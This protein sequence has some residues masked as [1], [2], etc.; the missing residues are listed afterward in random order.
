MKDA[1]FAIINEYSAMKGYPLWALKYMSDVF[2]NSLPKLTMNDEV[3][4][5]IDNIIA[6]CNGNDQKNVQLVTSTL[7]LI[8]RYRADFPDILNKENSFHNGFV[9]FLYSVEK[10]DLEHEEVEDAIDYLKK[11]LQTTTGYWTED[12]VSVALRNWRIEKNA[13]IV[14]RRRREE[15]E[16]HRREVDKFADKADK[17]TAIIGDENKARSKKVDARELIDHI[18]DPEML[19][20]IIDRII[21]LGYEQILDIILEE[22]AKALELGIIINEDD[23]V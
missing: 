17:Y 19:R 16:K 9:N 20:A 15:E 3:K 4:H 5:L 10:V 2:I 12:E 21:N 1:R 18:S 14:E 6:I 22:K 13:E 8:D 23:D 11:H 7:E